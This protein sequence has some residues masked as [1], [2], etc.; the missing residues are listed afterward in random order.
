[1]KVC[2]IHNYYRTSAPSGENVA[3]ES[4]AALL[5][6]HGHE[7][8]TLRWENDDLADSALAQLALG[9]TCTWN[10][11]AYRSVLRSL[12]RLE[13]DIV[14]IHNT[15]PQA[16]PA[17]L[18]AAR[19]F[20][21]SAIVM[22]IHN[23][24]ML[25]ANGLL[26]RNGQAC[27]ECVRAG[28]SLPAIRHG[29]YR[30]SRLRTLPVALS[31]DFHRHLGTYYRVPDAV[32]VLTAFQRDMLSGRVEPEKLH[33]KPHFTDPPDRMPWSEREYRLLFVGRLSAEKGL[34]V[35]IDAL[36]Q[37]PDAP[38][39]DIIG[40][41][42]ERAALEARVHSLGMAGRIRFH[43]MLPADRAQQAISRAKLLVIPSLCNETFSLVL[44]EAMALG[45]PVLASRI[46]ALKETIKDGW[47]GA[48][49]E[50]GH[51]EALAAALKQLLGDEERLR[52]MGD[53]AF[54]EFMSR[55]SE[56]SVYDSLLDIYTRARQ[57]RSERHRRVRRLAFR[58]PLGSNGLPIP[59]RDTLPSSAD[60]SRGV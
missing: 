34:N 59:K 53:H 11:S 26:F 6:A 39:C 30:S 12:R 8:V 46:G 14:H 54:H 1:M 13:P 40:D 52:Q 15:F 29:C 38:A 7:V 56:S 57:R 17:V 36:R 10:Q 25:C 3:V 16:S 27:T 50:A 41:G 37:V 45:V 22:T 44:R 60:S 19:R 49:F 24:R 31:I 51:P 18:Y 42:D 43:G 2:I 58:R 4:D 35:L 55:Y 20:D 48:L 5:R 33:I 23:Y 32:I 9:V 21:R 28:S 47:S